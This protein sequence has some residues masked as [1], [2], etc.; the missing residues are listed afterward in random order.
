MQFPM[1][2]PDPIPDGTSLST[3]DILYPNMAGVPL[4]SDSVQWEWDLQ[5]L[6]NGY[7]MPESRDPV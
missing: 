5:N 2:L 4:F 1:G 3:G 6:W 7:F